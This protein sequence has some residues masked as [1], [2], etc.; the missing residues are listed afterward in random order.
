MRGNVSRLHDALHVCTFLRAGRVMQPTAAS[1]RLGF[2]E[3]EKNL[4]FGT[5]ARRPGACLVT[6]TRGCRRTGLGTRA[7]SCGPSS[8]SGTSGGSYGKGN[9]DGSDDN[10]K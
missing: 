9:G 6:M 5:G 8:G 3:M 7:A 1:L 10:D 2:R 4:G